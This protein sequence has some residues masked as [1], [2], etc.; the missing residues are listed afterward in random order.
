MKIGHLYNLDSFKSFQDS[1]KTSGFADSFAGTVLARNLTAVDPKIFEK[2]FPELAFVNSGIQADNSGGYA[3]QIQSLRIEALGSFRTAGDA[4]DNK[5]KISLAG[6][7]SFIKVFE[8]EAESKWTDSEIKEAE[9]Q[10]INLPQRY[11]Q[12][13]NAIYLRE[14]DEIGLTGGTL[15]NEGLLNY[16]GFFSSGASGAIGTLTPTQMYDAIATLV[17]DQRNAVN[18]TPEYSANRVIMPVAV[19][20]KL[21]VTILNTAAGSSTVM[22]ALQ[23]NFPDVQFTASFRAA[24]VDGAS[25][26]V[27]FSTSDEAMK[28]RVPLALTIGEIIKL[29]SFNFH[30]DS[31]YRI[32]GLDV[33]ENTSG[34]ILTGL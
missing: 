13:H 31:K 2:K 21:S 12:Y 10:N 27:A 32:A 23:D 26:T 33:L 9:L 1:I 7:D 5:G 30:V 20:N 16:S 11:V 29:G 22:R 4:S 8:R 6:D 17:I 28:M 19:M 18:N 14:V 34:R 3:K 15:G 25:A 24:A